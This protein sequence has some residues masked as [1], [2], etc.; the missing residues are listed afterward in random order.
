MFFSVKRQTGR[1]SDEG[2][3]VAAG[4]EVAYSITF[5][6]ESNN[7]H[8]H[9]LVVV[10]EREKFLV[11][12]V[13]MG[14]APLLDMPDTISF[15]PTP[16]RKEAR[17]SLL[18]RNIGNKAG[19]FQVYA[20][21]CFSVAPAKGFLAPGETLQL[22]LE[23]S[24]SITGVHAGDLSVLYDNGRTTYTILQG[25]G[26]ELPV[27]L[28]SSQ[29][30]FLPTYISKLSQ[31]SFKVVNDSDMALTY[32]VKMQPT[33][34]E[35]LMATSRTLA[36]LA[37][38]DSKAACSRSSSSK[39]QNST[40]PSGRKPQDLSRGCPSGSHDRD[41]APKGQQGDCGG[42]YGY[43]VTAVATGACEADADASI[44]ASTEGDGDSILEDVGL[45]SRRELKKARKYAHADRQLFCSSTFAVF[46]AEGTVWPHSE[47]EVIVQF[48]PDHAKAFDESAWVELQGREERQLLRLSGRGLGAQAIFSY[49]SLDVGEVFVNTR[50]VYEVELMNRG[51]VDAEF[52]LQPCHTC[53]GSK[54][55]FQPDAG[56][57]SAGAVQVSHFREIRD[58]LCGLLSVVF[59]SS[60]N[61]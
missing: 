3:K 21:S 6:P 38:Y 50:H 20:T 46:P 61:S 53:F 2:S 48:Q 14:A 7:D 15:P 47:T 43:G 32:A 1:L 27:R 9:Q 42:S 49:D 45:A 17:R 55:S 31:K 57:L 29:L 30:K 56:V 54:F 22:S 18:V 33:P 28:S 16:I 23:F 59:W 25:E 34:V 10:T 5:Q 8:F 41:A 37:H 11:P 60:R 36:T 52:R 51:K 24:P 4:M 35:D 12:I 40:S 13:A 44:D 58:M 39:Y 19:G 26:Q